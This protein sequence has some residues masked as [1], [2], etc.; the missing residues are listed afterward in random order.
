MV[1]RTHGTNARR[2]FRQ[3]V[4]GNRSAPHLNLSPSK[5]PCLTKSIPTASSGNRFTTTCGCNIPNGSSQ[6]ASPLSAILTSHAL[7]NYS[8]I[9]HERDPT[10]LSLV[11]IP[12][13]NRHQTES[14][15][16]L[17]GLY[18]GTRVR[19]R[20]ARAFR[21]RCPLHRKRE[22]QHHVSGCAISRRQLPC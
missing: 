21:S 20:P 13:S 14:T 12:S 15:P 7:W 19:E 2:R 3:G 4:C 5:L 11:F 6:M 8:K 10:N 18:G 22:S 9:S 1:G 16:H 17:L